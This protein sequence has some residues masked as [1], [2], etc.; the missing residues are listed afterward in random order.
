MAI[1][2]ILV[3]LDNSPSCKSRLD[4]AIQIAKRHGAHL[5]GLFVL[6]HS[7]YAPRH[8]T[9]D[10]EVAKA[11]EAMFNLKTSGAG[12]SAEWLY[13]DWSVIGVQM[14]EIV[15]LYSY[16]TDLLIIGQPTIES[17][18]CGVPFDMP[19]R[20]GLTTGK[21]ILIVPYTGTTNNEVDRIMVAWKAGRE[22]SR[23]L[24]DSLPLLKAASNI[25]LVTVGSPDGYNSAP[26]SDIEKISSYLSRHQISV[27][28][29]QIQSPPSFPIGDMLLNHACEQKMDLIVMGGYA[30]SRRGAFMLGPVARHLMN[31]M[32]VPV[33]MSH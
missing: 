7:Y 13:V 17:N 24:H 18:S 22:S 26:E 30:A 3:H 20:L 5:K 19:E 12:I 11:T 9:S 1:K 23:T 8:T 25:N 31:H 14:T 2:D 10:L 28:H 29:D 6:S 32:T 15:T 16:Y 27:V 33:F 4:M 21:A